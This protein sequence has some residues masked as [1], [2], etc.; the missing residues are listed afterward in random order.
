M[1]RREAHHGLEARRN[2]VV[3]HAGLLTARHGDVMSMETREAV[4]FPSDEF[5]CVIASWPSSTYSVS[6][7]PAVML[8]DG[9]WFIPRPYCDIVGDPGARVGSR[10]DP[11]VVE[12]FSILATRERGSGRKGELNDQVLAVLDCVLLQGLFYISELLFAHE[13]EPDGVPRTEALPRPLL[14]NHAR[15][16]IVT[17]QTARTAFQMSKRY[18][19]VSPKRGAFVIEPVKFRRLWAGLFSLKRGM[20]ELVL[21]RRIHD[22]VQA[23]EALLWLK[24]GE[25]KP[26]FTARAK[27]LTTG[28]A[29]TLKS[30]ETAWRVR[31]ADEHMEPAKQEVA[32]VR[33]IWELVWK[34]EGFAMQSYVRLLSDNKL[35]KHFKSDPTIGS[36][37]SVMTPNDRRRLWGS[38]IDIDSLRWLRRPHGGWE[39]GRR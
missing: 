37:W 12:G 20:R 13:R 9:L 1:E 30:L 16:A 11:H 35:L 3:G 4:I 33:R 32:R 14:L 23:I 8:G 24:Q 34:M 10:F 5:A 28:T 31:C 36:F 18:L 6:Q 39:L 21:T 2:G 25:G 26:V 29:A 15:S 38:G 22:C 19:R 27:E 7:A 17:E